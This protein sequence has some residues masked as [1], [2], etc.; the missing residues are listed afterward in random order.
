MRRHA[1][2]LA[3]VI[4]AASAAT[5][6]SRIDLQSGT[7]RDVA[8]NVGWYGNAFYFNQQ[9]QVATGVGMSG[10]LSLYDH[11]N[12]RV[13]NIP[14][15]TVTGSWSSSQV[16]TLDWLTCYSTAMNAQTFDRFATHYGSS[17]CTGQPP[18]G[19]GGGGGGNTDNQNDGGFSWDGYGCPLLLNPRGGVWALTGATSAVLFDVDGD[20]EKER[21]GW[22]EA[23]SGLA[24]LAL[25]AN[26]NGAIDDGSELFGV[27]TVLPAGI[28]ASQGFEALRQHDAN[29]DG[30]INAADP[31][32]PR[33]LLWSDA[34]HDGTSV[35]AELAPLSS[36]RI[37]A[38][39]LSHREV[40]RRDEHGNMLR[41]QAHA[42]LGAA[43]QP[44][45]DVFLRIFP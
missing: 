33:L 40:G 43:R 32:W 25:D 30:V 42:L 38:L 11:L 17:T 8:P 1:L 10:N 13:R 45:Y 7:F 12:F 41:Y 22:P 31:V 5:A 23:D 18:Y 3:A 24:F 27:G 21:L 28:R 14:W 9:G 20:G 16:T 37:T 44:F 39:E 2:L 26:A 34:N 29:A 35:A 6:Q 15:G 4:V 36:T 19:G